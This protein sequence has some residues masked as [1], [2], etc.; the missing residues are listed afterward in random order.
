MRR[1]GM[2]WRWRALVGIGV[3]IGLALAL[4]GCQG[5]P[6]PSPTGTVDATATASTDVSPTAPP[7]DPAATA[8]VCGLAVAATRTT[9]KIFNDQM[10][11]FEQAAATN[12]EPAMFAAAEAI[13]QQ[14][15]TLA[16]TFTQLSQR[17]ID[18]AL[19]AVLTDIATALTQ[20]SS[21]SYTGTTVDIRKKLIDFTDA[22]NHACV[23]PTASS[24]AAPG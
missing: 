24:S 3:T 18:P 6:A 20:M 19:R 9:T 2:Q 16:T 10:A 22:L 4:A 13:N 14:F 8:Q 17:P 23:S 11:A 7:V 12:D 1:R 21:L 15:T 5:N